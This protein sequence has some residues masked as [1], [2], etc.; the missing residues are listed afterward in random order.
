MAQEYSELDIAASDAVL[1]RQTLEETI[2]MVKQ[3]E[4]REALIPLLTLSKTQEARLQLAALGF[5]VVIRFWR[6]GTI[7]RQNVAELKSIERL[8]A[9]ALLP[10]PTTKR[11]TK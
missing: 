2:P 10:S 9:G 1:I 3:S 8:Y 7:S 6:R 11:S 5:R 4:V